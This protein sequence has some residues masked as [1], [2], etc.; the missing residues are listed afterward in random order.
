MIN[1]LD[2]AVDKCSSWIQKI[3]EN[4]Q[5]WDYQMRMTLLKLDFKN[6]V[7]RIVFSNR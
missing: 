5:Q 2:L 6:E 4:P 1:K 7:H 3:N